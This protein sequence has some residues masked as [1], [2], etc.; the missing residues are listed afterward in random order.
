MIS[1]ETKMQIVNSYLALNALREVGYRSTATAIAELVDNSI[2]AE[3]DDIHI[4]T[5]SKKEAGAKRASYRVQR[6]AVLDNG[7]GM[8]EEEIANCLSLGWGT[9][10][11]TRE[12]LGRFGF[13]LKGAS[14]SQCRHIEI[15]S[16]RDDK[17]FK[18]YMDL[19]EIRDNDLQ[20][21]RPAV[22]TKVPKFVPDNFRKSGTLV[23]WSKLDKVDFTRPITLLNRMD[24]ELCRIYRHFLDDD[25][26]YGRKRNVVMVDYDLDAKEA[27]HQAALKANDPLYLLTPSNAPGSDGKSTNAQFEKPYSIP[28][29]YSPGKSSDV[30][31]RLSI[32]KPET[33]ALGGNSELGRHYGKNTGISFVRAGREIDFGDFDF[34]SRSDP[35]HRWW[36]I[37]VRFKPELDE[38]FGV[39]NNKQQIR[40]FRKIDTKNDL[41]VV[42]S[43]REAA[44]DEDSSMHFKAK[45]RLALS[46]N[47]DQKV[48]SMM[49]IIQARG[50]GKNTEQKVT[51]PTRIQTTV[52]EDLTNDNSKTS[53]QEA[54]EAKTKE[55]K[56]KERADLLSETRP[57]L[58]DA[59]RM[60]LAEA[61]VEFKV[62]ISKHSWPGNTFLDLQLVANAAVGKINTRSEF[63]KK[64]WQYLEDHDDA[65]GIN[66]L[67]IFTMAYIRTEDEF[68]PTHGRELFDD[69][70]DRWGTWVNTL[71]KNLD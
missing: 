41:D 68:R 35:R 36:G 66:A 47:L 31:I 8:L 63:Y 58:S 51:K 37:E 15:Y 46:D 67:Q 24:S 1:L 14:I 57:E 52:N 48:G 56:L 23:I 71:L 21:L 59:D 69:F 16:W 64:F 61:T 32:A 25:D 28:V 53:S 50:K 20:D 13:G 43:L 27:K 9:R 26:E 55:E 18:T 5:F 22:S 10:L 19:D 40:G 6:V 34:V 62:D 17:C 33:Q 54:A 44:K 49:D 3:A 65:M 4:M 60:R 11:N 30:E 38:L 45:M 29:E 2:E 70:R 42:R 7:K 12:G 39:T